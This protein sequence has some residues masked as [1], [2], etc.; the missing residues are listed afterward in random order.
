MK[1]N[2]VELNF[3]LYDSNNIKLRKR[4][5]KE[6]GKLR[7][8][9]KSMPKGADERTQIEYFCGKI[10]KM[11]DKVFYTGAGDEV[12]GEGNNLLKCM[13][14]YEQLVSDQIRQNNEYNAIIEKIRNI[15]ND[16]LND[17][18]ESVPDLSELSGDVD[19]SA[20]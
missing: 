11:F 12:C 13:N 3:E 16:N 14:A 7:G 17:L 2:G 8:I 20:D 4:Y 19:E 6:L 10:K 9:S 15:K 5:F 1:I 18:A